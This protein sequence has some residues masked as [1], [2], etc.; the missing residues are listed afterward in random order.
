MIISI[1]F[2]DLSLT[3]KEYQDIKMTLKLLIPEADF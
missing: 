3:I 1:K 2:S